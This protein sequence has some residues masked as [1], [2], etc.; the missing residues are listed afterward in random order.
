MEGQKEHVKDCVQINFN[1]N[2]EVNMDNDVH[3]NEHT[4]LEKN[5]D[6]N[7]EHLDDILLNTVEDNSDDEQLTYNSV[8]DMIK[9][10]VDPFKKFKNTR[11][12][13]S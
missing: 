6:A 9:C 5:V 13:Q 8:H 1:P 4:I 7:V 12:G 10:L 2:V 3:I 11:S